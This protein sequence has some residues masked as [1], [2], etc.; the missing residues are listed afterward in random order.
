MQDRGGREGFPV[1]RKT[2]MNG[3]SVEKVLCV[4]REVDR[5]GG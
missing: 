5:Y 3:H 4:Y 2:A 1:R